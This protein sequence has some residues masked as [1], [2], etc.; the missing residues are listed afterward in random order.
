MKNYLRYRKDSNILELFL[1]FLCYGSLHR[2]Q[3]QEFAK[4]KK[5]SWKTMERYLYTISNLPGVEFSVRH[6]LFIVG[7]VD[8]R[9]V[10][11]FI[12]AKE[13]PKEKRCTGPCGVIFIGIDA[14]KDNFYRDKSRRD[15]FTGFCKVC[16]QQS[17]MDGYWKNKDQ[18]LERMKQYRKRRKKWQ[19]R[20]AK[21]SKL[22][23]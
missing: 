11:K 7:A 21:N 20:E 8:T 1:D 17:S 4:T 13:I 9:G 19:P 3:L 16:S 2:T 10:A 6:N 14:V 22:K 12:P 18:R 23:S 5:V 15:G